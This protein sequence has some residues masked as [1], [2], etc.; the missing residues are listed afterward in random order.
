MKSLF[1]KIVLVLITVFTVSCADNSFEEEPLDDNFPFQIVLDAE[2]GGDLADAEDYGVELKFADY[3]PDLKLPNSDITITYAITD[4]EDDMIGNVAIDKI[5]YEVEENDCVFERELEFTSSSDGLSGTI[6]LSPD[7]DLGSVPDAF[8]VIFTLPGEDDTE[9]SFKVEFSSLQSSENL[10]LGSPNVFEYSVLD[11]DVAG[12]WE[13]EIGSEEEFEQFKELFGQLNPELEQLTF[14]DITGKVTAEFEFEEMKFLLELA[15]TEEVTTCEDGETETEIVNK[16]IEIETEY[17][18]EDNEIE[19]EG[20]HEIV[21]NEGLIE[22][23]LDYIIEAAYELDGDNLV[24]TFYKVIDED[25]YQAEEELF[26]AEDG[27]VLSFAK[28]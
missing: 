23:E 5:V 28:N 2:E 1:D 4:V 18:A 26:Y 6:T 19:F 14:E 27:I 13:M 11:N 22:D 8:E 17:D 25:N 20:S 21:D 10:L 3:L 12:E 9:G 7:L 24:L 15:E 16:E